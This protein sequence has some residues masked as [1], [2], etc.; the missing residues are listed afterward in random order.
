MTTLATL[1]FRISVLVLSV[2]SAG[3]LL[4]QPT[5]ARPN[6]LSP[7]G[8]KPGTA[9]RLVHAVRK[10]QSEVPDLYKGRVL[11]VGSGGG[12]VGVE[13]TYSL[14]DD[15]RL[16]GKTSRAATYTF[17][18]NRTPKNTRRVFWSVEN[19]CRIKKTAFTKPGNLYRFVQW[20]KGTEKHKVVWA[21]GDKTVPANYEKMYTGFMGMLP[22]SKS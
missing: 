1:L 13:T 4:A 19:R 3:S 15:G 6:S 5:A 8:K 2:V 12:V 20:R 21:P 17:L 10:T 16:F 11:T 14:L 9:P 7:P 22:K 18:G